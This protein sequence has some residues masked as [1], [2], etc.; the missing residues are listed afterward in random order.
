GPAE[1]QHYGEVRPSLLLVLPR[2]I[3]GVLVALVVSYYLPSIYAAIPFYDVTMPGF[4]NW[5]AVW[6]VCMLPAAWYAI[7]LMTTQYEIT[8]QR[9]FYKRGVLNRHRDQLEIVRIRDLAT[10]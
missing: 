10:Y 1:E 6:V 4:W 7:V 9:I 3:F 5:L 2:L 8:S